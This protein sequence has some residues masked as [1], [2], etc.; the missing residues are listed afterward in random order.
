MKQL[1]YPPRR[2]L[3]LSDGEPVL[4]TVAHDLEYPTTT[5]TETRRNTKNVE[6]EELTG[7]EDHDFFKPSLLKIDTS[8]NGSSCGGSLSS[9]LGSK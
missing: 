8:Q 7:V 3:A 4:A 5:T 1:M 2:R 6:A 9:Q